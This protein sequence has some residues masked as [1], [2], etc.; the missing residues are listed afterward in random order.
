M[1]NDSK[2]KKLTA[3]NF[4]LSVIK[5]F[6]RYFEEGGGIREDTDVI[7][8][9][10]DL[11]DVVKKAEEL[12][13]NQEPGSFEIEEA[14]GSAFWYLSN[15][16]SQQAIDPDEMVPNCLGGDPFVAMFICGLNSS[17]RWDDDE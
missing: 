7:R 6:G 16:E 15:P 11:A 17:V 4:M 10:E 5:D 9:G 13:L 2:Q 8:L 3:K 14:I 12:G 1:S